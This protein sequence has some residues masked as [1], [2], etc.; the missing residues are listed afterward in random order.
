MWSNRRLLVSF[1]FMIN[2]IILVVVRFGASTRTC[3]PNKFIHLSNCSFRHLLHSSSSYLMTNDNRTLTMIVPYSLHSHD[4]EH[5][6]ITIFTSKK[7]FKPLI[8]FHLNII[9]C[10]EKKVTFNWTSLES[11]STS[12][13]EFVRTSHIDGNLMYLSS[14]KTYLKN[15]TSLDCSSK[16]IYQTDV[17]QLFELDLKIE[18]TSKD[19]CTSD[20]SCYPHENYQCHSGQHRCHCRKPFQTYSI[21]DQYPICL[22]AVQTMDQCMTD[23]SRCLEWCRQNSSSTMCLCPAEISTKKFSADQREGMRLIDSALKISSSSSS[24]VL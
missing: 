16:T 1:M 20:Q 21:R 14:G 6:L 2:I 4:E 15:L 18:S 11:S 19:F 12:R 24:S 9:Q 13:G 3:L 17:E 5:A 7:S 8:R 10:T 22:Q 23:K